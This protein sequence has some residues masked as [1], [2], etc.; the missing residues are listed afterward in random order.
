MH[1]EKS[2]VPSDYIPHLCIPASEVQYIHVFW[3][4][5]EPNPGEFK[6]ALLDDYAERC[7][8]LRQEGKTVCVTLYNNNDP[9]WFS[10]DGGF[11][12][13]SSMPAY[14]NYQKQVI[15]ALSQ[16]VDLWQ[17]FKEVPAINDNSI[18]I[19]KETRTRILQG[20]LAICQLTAYTEIHRQAGYTYTDTD[21]TLKFVAVLLPEG[22]S[23]D[24]WLDNASNAKKKVFQ[25]I[26]STLLDDSSIVSIESSIV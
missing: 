25:S 22:C 14:V 2:F 26:E 1:S 15:S 21:G 6:T 9:N 7:R 23:M 3:N 5:I 12:A 24:G 13:L 16:Y 8:Q 17:P 10:K 20:N 11:T 18:G 19:I 4:A